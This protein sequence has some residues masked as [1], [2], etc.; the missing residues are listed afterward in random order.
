VLV[1]TRFRVAVADQPNWRPRLDT[2]LAVLA[3]RDGFRSGRIGRAA[4]DVE[5]LVLAT[6]WDGVGAYRRA[7]SNL[8]VKMTGVP[9]LSEAID[10]PGAFEVLAAVG[11]GSDGLAVGPPAATGQ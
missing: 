2:A 6:E 1:L 3:E 7:L 10:E 8:E 9:V 5:L 11:L 4:D